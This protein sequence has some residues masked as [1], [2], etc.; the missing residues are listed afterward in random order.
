MKICK[1]CGSQNPDNV[2]NCQNCGAPLEAPQQPV[3][4]QY[5]QQ[6]APPYQGQ[7]QYQ[8]PQQ[9]GIPKN[10]MIVLVVAIIAIAAVVIAAIAITKGSAKPE[11]TT[12]ETT[13]AVTTTQAPTTA[14]PQTTK[15][16]DNDKNATL[17]KVRP[18][19][20]APKNYNYT[21]YDPEY[22]WL[23]SRLVTDD[24]LS[25]MSKDEIDYLRNA[26]YAW[27]GY[28]FKKDK[29]WNYYCNVSWYNPYESSMEVAESNFNS[30]EKKNIDRIVKYQKAHGQR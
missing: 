14:A 29:Y 1:N 22:Y 30:T 11:E 26:P 25:T 2:F 7:P 4:Q 21:Y 16:A 15:A 5:Y 20:T 6:P 24:F 18:S 13:T 23:D 9:K 12:I 3:Q 19:T 27:H 28:I 10:T 17:K 8:Q